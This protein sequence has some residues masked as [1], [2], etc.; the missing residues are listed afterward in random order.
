MVPVLELVA[1]AVRLIG[2][3]PFLVVAMSMVIL[4]VQLLFVW[5]GIA[6][7]PVD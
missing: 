5:L 6:G 4:S 1:E 2:L 3:L 7:P